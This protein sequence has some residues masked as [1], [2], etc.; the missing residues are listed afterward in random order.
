[1]P[2]YTSTTV[3]RRVQYDPAPDGSVIAASFFETTLTNDDDPDDVSVKPW[4]SVTHPI[5]ND[6][7]AQVAEHAIEAR[8]AQRAAKVAEKTARISEASL[9]KG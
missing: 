7:A 9:R 8:D 4:E 1:M 2:S 6:L 3:L 5:P